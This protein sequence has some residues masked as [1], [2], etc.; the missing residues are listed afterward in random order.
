[1]RDQ[2]NTAAEYV[3]SVRDRIAAKCVQPMRDKLKTAA[4]YAQS[5]RDKISA[6]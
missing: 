4:E 1:M 3:Q 6:N 5:M 2:L